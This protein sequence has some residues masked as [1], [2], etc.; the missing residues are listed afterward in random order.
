M[1]LVKIWLK[2]AVFVS[3]Y[4]LFILQRRI[5]AL[6][7]L[8]AF[9]L[10]SSISRE[11]VATEEPPPEEPSHVMHKLIASA[12]LHFLLGCFG[13]GVSAENDDIDMFSLKVLSQL[14]VI[15]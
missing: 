2:R 10:S 12:Q 5:K 4:E 11:D 8:S 13:L 3:N 14:A 15:L 1:S 7:S 9:N 6:K